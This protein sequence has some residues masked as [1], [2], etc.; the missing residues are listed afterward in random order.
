MFTF[1]ATAVAQFILLLKS[2]ASPP[3]SAQASSAVWFAGN[4]FIIGA[5]SIISLT[6]NAWQN[7]HKSLTAMASQSDDDNPM[8]AFC[9]IAR[10]KWQEIARGPPFDSVS[11]RELRL[12]LRRDHHG[13]YQKRWPA[14][15]QSS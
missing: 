11:A 1:H 3:R 13:G 14:A 10:F 5:D 4:P 15:D 12:D 6:G 8:E 7:P 9:L 2:G